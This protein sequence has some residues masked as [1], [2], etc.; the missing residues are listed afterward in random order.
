MAVRGEVQQTV[1]A[2]IGE[3]LIARGVDEFA[4][5]F[6]GAGAFFEIDAP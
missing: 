2:H 5:I 3:T 1:G 4:E 6:K